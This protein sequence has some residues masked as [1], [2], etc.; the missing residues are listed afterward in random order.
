MDYAVVAA[1][2]KQY[3]VRPGMLLEVDYLGGEA[4][5]TVELKPVLAVRKETL[6]QIGQPDLKGTSVRAQIVTH[7]RGPKGVSFKFKRR[8]GY[9]R[10]VG[11]R[12]ALTR[13]KI[14]EISTNGAH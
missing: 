4:G 8:K 7:R 6:F 11:Y 9:H 14:L 12:Q 2:G 1:G 3:V 13:L 10:K 5:E